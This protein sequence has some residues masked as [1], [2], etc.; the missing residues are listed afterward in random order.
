MCILYVYNLAE[1]AE[2]NAKVQLEKIT[3]GIWEHDTYTNTNKLY[4]KHIYK[5]NDIYA[6]KYDE[7]CH[8]LY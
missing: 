7:I 3:Y 8:A 6:K 5:D 1:V 2:K 4:R